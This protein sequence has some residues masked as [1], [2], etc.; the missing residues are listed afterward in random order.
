MQW[1]ILEHGKDQGSLN[2]TRKREDAGG[3]LW[4]YLVSC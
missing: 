2:F 4:S 1:M 3:S